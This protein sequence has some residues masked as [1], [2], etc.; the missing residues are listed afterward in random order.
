MKFLGNF[1][2]TVNAHRREV[3]GFMLDQDDGD[4]YKAYLSSTELRELAD[5]CNE[6]AIW[7][8]ARADRASDKP[9]GV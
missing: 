2:P 7:L 6:M 5:A 4:G 3:K 9:E 1:G 8:D